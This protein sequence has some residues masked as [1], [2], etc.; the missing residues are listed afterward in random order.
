METQR[1]RTGYFYARFDEVGSPV[2][3]RVRDCQGSHGN[4]ADLFVGVLLV[5]ALSSEI[6]RLLSSGYGEGISLTRVL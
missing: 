1:N 5:P 2:E 6:R 4:L 3:I